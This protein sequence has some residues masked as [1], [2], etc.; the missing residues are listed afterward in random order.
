MSKAS[1]HKSLMRPRF[2]LILLLMLVA[3]LASFRAVRYSR[4][5]AVFAEARKAFFVKMYGKAGLADD[6]TKF[7][8]RDF[9]YAVRSDGSYAQ[10]E[11]TELPNDGMLIHSGGVT[12][13]PEKRMIGFT[14]RTR[15]KTTFH[16][17][18]EHIIKPYARFTDSNC[19]VHPLDPRQFGVLGE[20]TILGFRVIRLQE[21]SGG[22]QFWRAPD[23]DCYALR[24]RFEYRRPDGTVTDYSEETAISVD[25]GEPPPELFE[26]PGDYVE[27]A[28]SQHHQANMADWAASQQPPVAVPPTSQ[29]I[30]RKLANKDQQYETLK[31]NASQ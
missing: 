27:R 15:S 2:L 9:F 6:P 30:Q 13:V 19:A 22:D 1:E 14:Q 23:L 3:G 5:Q 29:D 7:R 25:V 21:V 16:L 26:I 20:D 8:E 18:E 28:P 24:R 10:G 4:S 12:L 11:Y 31:A 17:K